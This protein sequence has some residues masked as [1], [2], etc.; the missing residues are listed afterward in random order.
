MLIYLAL[1][2]VLLSLHALLWGKTCLS[3]SLLILAAGAMLVQMYLQ[4]GEKPPR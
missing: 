3:A 2:S 4:R 1:S